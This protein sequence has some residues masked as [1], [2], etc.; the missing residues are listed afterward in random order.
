V[1][2][3]FKKDLILSFICWYCSFASLLNYW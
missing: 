2:S 1:Y 3:K